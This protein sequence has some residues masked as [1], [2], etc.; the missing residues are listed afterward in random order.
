M[1]ELKMVLSI[2]NFY[3]ILIEIP[4]ASKAI[5]PRIDSQSNGAASQRI[6]AI[7]IR[8]HTMAITRPMRIAHQD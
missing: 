5:T 6:I 1:A 2:L 8:Q 3:I 4:N 7:T